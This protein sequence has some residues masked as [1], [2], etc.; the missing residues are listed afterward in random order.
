MHAAFPV[1]WSPSSARSTSPVARR[2]F[3]VRATLSFGPSANISSTWGRQTVSVSEGGRWPVKRLIATLTRAN[4]RA[5]SCRDQAQ[6]SSARRRALPRS[7]RCT[8]ATFWS[9]RSN[10]RE[11][12]S[13]ESASRGCG[14][15]G[16]RRPCLLRYALKFA[17]RSRR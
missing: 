8:S 10:E 4:L 17:E 9:M 3:L 1:I 12:F 7:C 5:L 15:F 11:S 16:V 6:S 13:C 14:A 2:A